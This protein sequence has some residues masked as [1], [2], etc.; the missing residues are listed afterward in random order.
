MRDGIQPW[1]W[2]LLLDDQET[3]TDSNW[4]LKLAAN[5]LL[6]MNWVLQWKLPELPLPRLL[7]LFIWPEF[8]LKFC[9]P[10]PR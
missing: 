7:F 4:A 5:E 9:G 2:V 8:S 3:A 1:G 6:T 10:L